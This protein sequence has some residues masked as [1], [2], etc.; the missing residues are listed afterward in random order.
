MIQIKEKLIKKG[1]KRRRGKTMTKC[2]GVT[3]HNTGNHDS[4]ADALANATYFCNSANDSVAGCHYFIDDTDCYCV[5]PDNEIVE[6]SGKRA[7]NDTTVC[8][9]IC[10]NSDGD[11][12]KATDRGAELAAEILK[13]KGFSKAVWKEN[14]FQ[15]N[16]WSGK[17]CPE[18][19]RAGKPYNWDTFINTVNK[20]IGISEKPQNTAFTVSRLL[21]YKLI[22]MR[23]EDVR[24]V[25]QVLVNNGIGI[26]GVDGIFGK[27]TKA[28]IMEWQ[29]RKGLTIDGIVGKNTCESMGGKWNL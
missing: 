25:Q 24:A 15:H 7:G 10:D 23:G 22:L 3:I 18:D 1:T 21:K 14:L 6:H 28:G 19:I 27:R 2:A 13:K 12:K 4:G 5:T 16:D 11:L 20:Y 26:G 9:E 17:N 8:I 29:K